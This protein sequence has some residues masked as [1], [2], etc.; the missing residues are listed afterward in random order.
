[1]NKTHGQRYTRLYRVW[2]GIKKRCFNP[3]HPYY[4]HYGG[5]GITV[6]EEWK[7]SFEAFEMWALENGYAEHLTI[8]R[9]DNNGNYC[10]E[11]CRFVTQTE[12]IRNRSISRKATINGETK[13]LME[14]A[15]EH[16]LLYQTVY[17]RYRRGLTGND[18]IKDVSK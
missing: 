13:S 7:D 1:M 14:W 4:T 10:P 9:I 11:N 5:R 18:L 12:Q 15:N 17:R 3:S 2:G 8:D 16:G 6:C